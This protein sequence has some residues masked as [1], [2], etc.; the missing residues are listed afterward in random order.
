MVAKRGRPEFE[1]TKAQRDKVAIAK[2]GG[3]SHDEIALGLGVSRNTL[4]KHFAVELKAG[5]YAK[6]LE[7]MSAQHRAAKGGN[8]AAQKAYLAQTPWLEPTAPQPQGDEA[9]APK[10]PPKGKKEQAQADAVTAQAGT[11][12]DDLLPGPASTLQ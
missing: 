2:G 6:R 9:P 1:P 4:E 7:V 5:A 3:M 8:V 10:E 11:G 12:W